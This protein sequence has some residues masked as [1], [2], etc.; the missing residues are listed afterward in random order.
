V[1]YIIGI[2]NIWFV[3]GFAI[4]IFALYFFQK[5]AFYKLTDRRNKDKELNELYTKQTAKILTNFILLKIFGIK[6]AEIRQLETY[7]K[8][9]IKNYTVM[10][11]RFTG[12]SS[13][14]NLL[15]MIFSFGAIGY[16][17][18]LFLQGNILI[19]TIMFFL[20]AIIYAR[21]RFYAFGVFVA[22]MT[23]KLTLIQRF[24]E[25]LEQA[26]TSHTGTMIELNNLQTSI[27]FENINFS[28]EESKQNLFDQLSL[29]LPYGQKTAFV[30]RS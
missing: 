8:E 21:E 29:I 27:T 14:A 17:G 12:V 19:G 28:Y 18:W 16:L 7:G 2:H 20:V 1:L 23:E 11:L 9:R 3:V 24:D 4:C 13:M 26:E 25:V 5:Y 15:L 6:E 30:G 10:K 22:E